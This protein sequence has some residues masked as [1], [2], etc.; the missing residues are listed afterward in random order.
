VAIQ[1]GFASVRDQRTIEISAEKFDFRMHAE[2]NLRIASANAICGGSGR[3][4]KF[5]SSLSQSGKD[6]A[7]DCWRAR[8]SDFKRSPCR[9]PSTG[10]DE[11][12]ANTYIG[13]ARIVEKEQK[14][15]HE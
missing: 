3:A 9:L 6:Q 8:V 10:R 12:D 15:A 2:T 11:W 7:R 13:G 4:S 5:P 14:L 1:S